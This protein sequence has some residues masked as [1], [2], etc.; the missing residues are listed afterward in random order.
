MSA[1]INPGSSG[2]PLLNVNGEV[3]GINCAGII[4]A[5]SVGY[6]IPI[7]DLKIVL[8]DLYKIKLLRKP[9]LGVLYNNATIE[10]TEFLG[11]PQPG[12]C[13][14]V[15]IVKNSTLDKAGVARGDM[16]YAINGYRVDIYGEMCVPWSEDKISITDYVSRLS[17]GDDVRLIIYRDGKKKE[18]TAKFSQVSMPAIREIYPGYEEVDYEV[19][20][21]MVI[22]ELTLN[23]ISLLVKKGVSGL[24]K[25]AEMKNQIDPVLIVTHIFPTSQIYRARTLHLGATINEINGIEVHTLKDLRD[26]LKDNI[27]S[28]FVTL[29]ISDNITRASDNILIALPFDKILAEESRLSH[30]YKYPISETVKTLLLARVEKVAQESKGDL[31]MIA[32]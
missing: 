20:A 15:D 30:D 22:M 11:N 26:A 16:V 8:P 24:S 13:Y 23:H 31:G 17:I 4:E 12:G 29:R 28:K 18:L 2:G 3:V 7:N 9:F 19:F 25:Y 6:I 32:C 27:S 5:Q 21:G 1:A 10:L 14:V